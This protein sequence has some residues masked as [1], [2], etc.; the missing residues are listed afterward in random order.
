MWNHAPEMKDRGGIAPIKAGEM[1][2]LVAFLF[3]QRYFFEP[4]DVGRGKRVYEGKNCAMC[5]E[6][7]RRL[8]GAPDLAKSVEEFSPVTLTAAAFRHGLPM[9]RS[10]KQQGVSWQELEPREMAD[11]IS[12]L[13]S[14]LI[15]RVASRHEGIQ[16]ASVP[17]A[18]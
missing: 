8:M 14:R 11:L 7:G 16:R 5:H 1:A 4:G 12:Y 2:N 18:R 3:S 17:T 13:N 9:I 15:T 10:M 6:S